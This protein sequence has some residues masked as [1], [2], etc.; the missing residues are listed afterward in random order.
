MKV[1]IKKYFPSMTGGRS[2][3]EN[4]QRYNLL[5][6]SDFHRCSSSAQLPIIHQPVCPHCSLQTHA[7]RGLGPA[8][9]PLSAPGTDQPGADS[10]SQRLHC[11]LCTAGTRCDY[12]GTKYL[13]R[14]V[15]LYRLRNTNIHPAVILPVKKYMN[16]VNCEK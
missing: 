10:C 4:V 1:L 9:P 11:H 14:N 16:L 15:N 5:C 2:Q 12:P 13:G 6:A 3:E 8:V 7:A